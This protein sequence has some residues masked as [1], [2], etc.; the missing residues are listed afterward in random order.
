MRIREMLVAFTWDKN[1]VAHAGLR[2]VEVVRHLVN[3]TFNESLSRK[4]HENLTPRNSTIGK[5]LCLR[6]QGY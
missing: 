4:M 3:T 2:I 5:R 1:S 6:K